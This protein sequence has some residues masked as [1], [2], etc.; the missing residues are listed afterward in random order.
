M[1]RFL[2][3]FLYT[4]LL[5]GAE[6]HERVLICG[7]CRNVESRLE[8]TIMIMESIGRL[9]DDYRILVYENNSTD[10][11]QTIL[12]SWAQANPKVWVKSEILSRKELEDLIIN[13]H[14]DGSLFIPE[15]ISRARNIVLEEALSPAYEDFPYLIWMD[16]DFVKFPNLDGFIDTFHS[17]Q[18][19]DAVFAYGVD[20]ANMYWDWYAFRDANYP[21]GSELLGMDWW[22]MDKQLSLSQKD[23]WYPVYSAFGG[24][25]IYKKSSIQGCR[26]SAL[27]TADLE[28]HA[29]KLMEK[30]GHPQI[31][32]YRTFNK[33][34]EAIHLVEEA[35]PHLPLILNPQIGVVLH[36]GPDA[37]IWRM[38]SFVYQFPSVCEH[39]PFHASMIVRGYDK[40]YINPRLVF[41]YGD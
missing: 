2:L 8:K 21:I 22:Y 13:V 28:A 7:V 26:Y 34:L 32:K 4:A 9:F 27:A 12:L 10:Q 14:S 36:P 35:T 38:S 19:W 3:L 33:N 1:V 40:L 15:Q 11:T 17:L 23:P 30:R 41:I 5:S 25:G 39:V 24:C 31:L 37:L 29:K 16:M 6:I 18:E 20:P